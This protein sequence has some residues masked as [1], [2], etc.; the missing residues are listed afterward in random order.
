MRTSQEKDRR[1][2]YE[3]NRRKNDPEHREKL[4]AYN[5][6]Y[7]NTDKFREWER[8]YRKKKR[9]NP[10]YRARVNQRRREWRKSSGYYQRQTQKRREMRLLQAPK[11]SIVQPS[12]QSDVAKEQKRAKDREYKRQLRANPVSNAKINQ[13]RRARYAKNPNKQ[14]EASHHRRAIERGSVGQVSRNIKTKLREAQGNKCAF[15]SQSLTR[16]KVHLDHIVPLARGG[17]HTDLNLQVLC[18]TCNHRKSA[19]DPIQFAQE[20]GKL[21]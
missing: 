10:E 4:Y 8:E 2:E 9:T 14:I 13:Q 19:K 17:Q 20:N 15:C 3:R 12:K 6:N 11:A 1:N 16:K 21:F 18:S 7:R 5:R